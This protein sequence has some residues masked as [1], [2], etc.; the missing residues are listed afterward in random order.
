MPLTDGY[1]K[2]ETQVVSYAHGEILAANNVNVI[3]N[4]SIRRPF[5]N[6]WGRPAV[7]IHTGRWTVEKGERKPLKE[8]VQV[9]DL[10][11]NGY[12]DPVFLTANANALRVD[13]W[14]ELDRQVQLCYRQR[15]SAWKDLMGA[16]PLGG[17]NG[18]NRM[19]LEYEAMSDPGEAVV[20]MDGLGEAR[21]DS[22]LFKLRALPLPITHSDFTFSERRLAISGN[23]GTPFDTTMAEACARRIG[24]KVEKTTIGVDSGVTYGTVSTGTSAMEGTSTVW[25]YTNY[26]YRITKSDFTCPADA[27]WSPNDTYNEFLAAMRLMKANKIYGPFVCYYSPDWF[28]Y[29]N[30]PFSTAGGNHQGKTLQ[31]MLKEVPG[32][33][34]LRELDYLTDDWTLIFIQ[35]TSDVVR[36]VNGMDITT[37]QWPSA[38]GMRQ[39]FKTMCIH[40]PLLRADYEQKTGILHG[41][42]TPA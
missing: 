7:M 27:G 6:E 23:M 28:E 18:M 10:L 24:E 2:P 37:V 26:P 3:Q 42:A 20:D 41:T 14:R 4:P 22:P 8:A 13:Q 9:V 38:G 15:L 39:H 32:V 40:V 1:I 16:N 11:N 30:R 34:D 36:A 29:F 5:F 33:S 25:G 12:I 17:F 31:Q 19:T 35:M 21:T